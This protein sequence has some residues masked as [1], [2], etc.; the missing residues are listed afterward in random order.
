MV[1]FYIAAG[2]C[3]SAD[4]FS[5]LTRRAMRQSKPTQNIA[6]LTICSNACSS[7]I[8]QCREK[9]CLCAIFCGLGAHGD[10]AGAL[11]AG[12]RG[13][14]RI[15]RRAR[16]AVHRQSSARCH[17]RPALQ[18]ATSRCIPATTGNSFSTPSAGMKRTTAAWWSRKVA[19]RGHQP[20][21]LGLA[22]SGQ[23]GWKTSNIEHRTTNTQFLQ[24]RVLMDL[25]DVQCWLLDVR[26]CPF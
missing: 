25:L 14:S 8:G 6:I 3:E 4:D 26:C 16:A 24:R 5:A 11:P 19:Q 7:G 20:R 10:C 1:E 18:S 17:R 23:V 21:R 12:A 9:I 13:I 2:G 15:A 22:V